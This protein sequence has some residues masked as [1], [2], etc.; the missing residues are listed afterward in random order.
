M[1]AIALFVSAIMG[2]WRKSKQQAHEQ[3]LA[4]ANAL[5][6]SQN[7]AFEGSQAE[8]VFTKWWRTPVRPIITYM[9]MFSFMALPFIAVFTEVGVNMEMCTNVTGL[10]PWLTGSQGEVCEYTTLAPGI[11]W[12]NMHTITVYSVV[13]Y[14]FGN[15]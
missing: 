11:V 1:E 10:W 3:Q 15:R 8:D 4:M 13:G 14:W 7:D 5:N 2:A 12:T 6:K 9:C